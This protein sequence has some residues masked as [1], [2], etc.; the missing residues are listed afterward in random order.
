MHITLYVELNTVLA[1]YAWMQSL[2]HCNVV[3]LVSDTTEVRLFLISLPLQVG[4]P[5]AAGM[6][7]PIT[8]TILT[9]SIAGALM[10]LSS[11]GVMANSLL[12]RLKFSSGQRNGRR[13]PGSIIKSYSGSDLED[14]KER[15]EKRLS[16]PT[17]RGT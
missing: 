8:G 3:L 17:W 9:P 4:I 12:L 6:L 15:T 16:G 1:N 7:L 2:S 11:V 14:Q 13:G 10:G 5:I